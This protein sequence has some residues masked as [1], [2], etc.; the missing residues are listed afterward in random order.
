MMGWRGVY[1]VCLF[2]LLFLKAVRFATSV[3]KVVVLQSYLNGIE[4]ELFVF[5]DPLWRRHLNF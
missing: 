5:V 1:R 3:M 4:M 2:F